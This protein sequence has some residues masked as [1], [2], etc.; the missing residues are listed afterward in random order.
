MMCWLRKEFKDIFGNWWGFLMYVGL[1]G[2]GTWFVM[3]ING[4]L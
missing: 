4:Y 2:A 3:W 1:A